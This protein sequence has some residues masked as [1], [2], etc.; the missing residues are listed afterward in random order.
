[1]KAALTRMGSALG[2]R[3]FLATA[4]AFAALALSIAAFAGGGALAQNAA[5][6]ARLQQAIA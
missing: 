3:K 5:D 4:G 6:C 1:M 2:R